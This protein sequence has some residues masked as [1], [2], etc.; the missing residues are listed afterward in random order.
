M[1]ELRPGIQPIGPFSCEPVADSS[2]LHTSAMSDF[3]DLR[4]DAVPAAA[5][6]G[7]ADAAVSVAGDSTAAAPV[8]PRK[9]KKS[10]RALVLL[11]P[12]PAFHP[13]QTP[14]SLPCSVFGLSPPLLLRVTAQLFQPHT[15]PLPPQPL[16]IFM[17]TCLEPGCRADL[18]R[19]IAVTSAM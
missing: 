5:N 14:N 16:I 18:R 15:C 4:D 11:L 19:I 17:M 13:D 10:S 12:L 6:S 1:Y 9:R 7:E 2:R 8:N 3:D